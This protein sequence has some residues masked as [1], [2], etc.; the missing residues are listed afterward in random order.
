VNG[1]F[2]RHTW[3]MHRV[4]L[5]LVS[6]GLAVWGFLT[7]IIYARYGSQ[8]KALLESGMLPKEFARLGGAD[9]FSLSGAIALGFIHPIPIILSSVFAVGFSASAI[10][11]ERQRGTLEVALA[12]PLSRR[13]LYVT[14]LVA[15]LAF[16]AANV[17]A[18]LTGAVAGS[19]FAGVIRELPVGNLPFVWLNG[20]LLFAALAGVGLA[21]SVSFDRAAQAT[22]LTLTFALVNYFLEILGSLWPAA[23]YL[24]P[25]SLFHYLKPKAILSGAAAPLDDLVLIT[26]FAIAIA[27]ALIVFPRRDLP[28]PS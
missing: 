7:P 27:W 14:L 23:E 2:F 20:V 5:A 17:T 16:V 3:R 11:G 6:I 4:R 9:I 19:A 8:F 15:S 13:R 1:A 28:A 25:Y 10:A 21:A 12:R 18:L 26:V 22:G 24:E